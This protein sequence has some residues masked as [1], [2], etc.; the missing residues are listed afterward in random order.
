MVPRCADCGYLAARNPE[1]KLVEVNEDWR[2][3]GLTTWPLLCFVRAADWNRESKERIAFEVCR[4][5]NCIASI[6][7][8]LGYSPRE[9]RDM[10]LEKE[11]LKFQAEQRDKDRVFQFQTDQSNRAFQVQQKRTDRIWNVAQAVIVVLL[12]ALI[13]WLVSSANKPHP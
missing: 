6:E 7:W 13:S 1:G 8:Q 4:E 10:Y 11:M 5:R 3:T 9:H 12:S 2:L